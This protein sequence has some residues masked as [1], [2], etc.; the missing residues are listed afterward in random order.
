MWVLYQ[1][2]SLWMQLASLFFTC[3]GLNGDL[4]VIRFF[5][6]MAYLMLFLNALLGS[7]LW[8]N[9][10][11]VGGFFLDSLL[12]S[13]VG[14][15]VHGASLVCLLLDE[16]SPNLTDDQQ[17][18]WRLL[19]RTGGLSPKLFETMIVPYLEVV[20]YNVGDTIPTE[21]HFYIVYQGRVRLQVVSMSNNDG[22]S[23]TTSTTTYTILE[24]RIKVAGEMFDFKHLDLLEPD[25]V[26][27]T[28]E[29]QCSA[30][31]PATKLFRFHKRDTS[32]IANHRFAKTL[33]QALLIN[34]LANVVEEYLKDTSGID[35]NVTEDKL[36]GPLKEWELPPETAAG[37]GHALHH[38]F[39]HGFQSMRKAF[40]APWPFGGHPTGIR[41]T[42]LRP[43]PPRPPPSPTAIAV[44]VPQNDDAT[45][46]SPAAWFPARCV[47]QWSSTSLS[48]AYRRNG[49]S[50]NGGLRPSLAWRVGI[51]AARQRGTVT[52]ST[53]GLHSN[54]AMAVN[55]VGVG[56]VTDGADVVLNV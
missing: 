11:N 2:L 6:F 16:R 29:L 21:D 30:L 17:A 19:Y 42:Q 37:S 47:Q 53:N 35:H 50:Q 14:L 3:S 8:P 55:S 22:T 7:P 10:E 43:P 45:A 15:Y 38:P 24:D 18:L 9:V 56:I 25:S 49:G 20:E 26:F 36:F 13:L 44:P 23:T 28:H 5:L 31:T 46:A 27:F 33:W 1:P 34:N 48:S 41:Q 52:N 40:S 4:L 12:W 51:I 54:G 39:R 32:C